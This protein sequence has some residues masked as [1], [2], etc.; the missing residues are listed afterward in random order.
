MPAFSLSGNWKRRVVAMP[1]RKYGAQPNTKNRRP[2]RRSP[3][4]PLSQLRTLTDRAPREA[5]ESDDTRGSVGA[6]RGA[7]HNGRADGASLGALDQPRRA[8]TAAVPRGRANRGQSPRP[9]P[10]TAPPD[11]GQP[12]FGAATA[13]VPAA[14]RLR[15]RTAPPAPVRPVADP[16]A[17]P[18]PRPGT[19][20]PPGAAGT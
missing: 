5:W 8:V 4:A 13:V 16:A 10:G 1:A 14:G 2:A 6:R 7:G 3:A 11:R 15:L 17:R 18:R 9:P 12:P 19:A 20:P